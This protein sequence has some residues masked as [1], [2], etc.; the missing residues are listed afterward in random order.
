MNVLSAKNGVAVITPQA[1]RML[2]ECVSKDQTRYFMERPYLD[3]ENKRIS[4]TDGRRLVILHLSDPEIEVLDDAGIK[5]G[6][7]DLV[8]VRKETKLV[9]VTEDCGQFP[10]IDRVLPDYSDRPWLFKE[11]FGL[12][13][14]FDIDS[15]IIAGLILAIGGPINLDFLKTLH[16]TDGINVKHAGWGEPKAIKFYFPGGAFIA[17]PMV[18]DSALNLLAVSPIKLG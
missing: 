6:H 7:Y 8:K 14:K 18:G 12:S 13:G 11:S 1:F 15:P 3:M 16:K 5:D 10:N 4:A 17:M 2:S 9:P